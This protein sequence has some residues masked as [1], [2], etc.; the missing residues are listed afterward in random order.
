MAAD[1]R[2]QTVDTRGR[3]RLFPKDTPQQG[4][5]CDC[6]VF[7]L[8]IADFVGRGRKQAMPWSQADVP[9]FRVMVLRQ[10]LELR[11]GLD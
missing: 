4:N 5:D 10:L 3:L 11:I 2:Q 9:R 1:K 8:K 7:V 6:G